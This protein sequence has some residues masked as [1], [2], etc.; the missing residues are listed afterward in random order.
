MKI[1]LSQ[2][3]QLLRMIGHSRGRLPIYLIGLLG[4]ASQSLLMNLVMSRSLKG[5]TDAALQ[6]DT[7]ILIN[8]LLELSIGLLVLTLLFPFFTY[9]FDSTVKRIT[10]NLRKDV[11]RQIQRL[12]MSAI[13]SSHSGDL[14]SRLTNDMQ[15]AE[16][17]YGWQLSL[18]IMSTVAGIGSI[19]II[20]TVNV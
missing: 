13:E 18:L 11:F 12:P 9:A 3:R 8:T 6:K 5:L 20:L 4:V 17:A 7:G 10:G 19:V 16:N 2:L 1:I 14:L 15:T